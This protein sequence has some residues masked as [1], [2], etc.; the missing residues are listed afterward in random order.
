LVRVDLSE[1]SDESVDEALALTSEDLADDGFNPAELIE[2]EIAGLLDGII[3][4]RPNTW[5][6][7]RS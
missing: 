6:V 2:G 3:R 1:T 4:D 7:A 5:Q